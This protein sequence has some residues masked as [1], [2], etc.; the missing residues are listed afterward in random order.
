MPYETYRDGLSPFKT[1]KSIHNRVNL[2]LTI[3]IKFVITLFDIEQGD[4]FL[5]ILLM[6]VLRRTE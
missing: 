2:G 1:L 5:M 3:F 6:H 4:F